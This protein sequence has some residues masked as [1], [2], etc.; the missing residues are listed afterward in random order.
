VLSSVM[1]QPLRVCVKLDSGR[2]AAPRASELRARME[3]DP[4]VRA[5]LER[6]GGQISEVKRRSED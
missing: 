2:T 1:G 4:I 6:F 5:M 3:E